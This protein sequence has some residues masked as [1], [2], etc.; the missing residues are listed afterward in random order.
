MEILIAEDD[1]ISRNLLKRMLT[2]MGHQVVEVENGRQAWDLLRKRL[3][4]F[5]VSDW[6]MPEMDG[7]ELCRNIRAAAFD[8]YIYMIV[9]TAKDRKKDL[10]EVFQAGADDYIP[11]P[12]DPEE[13]RARIMTGLRVIDLEERHKRMQSS[14]ID[15]HN[16]LLSIIDALQEQILVINSERR[17]VTAN[18]AFCRALGVSPIELVGEHLAAP[19]EDNQKQSLQSKILQMAQEAFETGRSGEHRH[20]HQGQQGAPVY[21]QF[22][23]LPMVDETAQVAQVILVGKEIH[24]DHDPEEEHGVRGDQISTK[25]NNQEDKNREIEVLR[26][27][28]AL[29]RNQM[30]QSEKMAAIGQLSAGVAHEINNPTGFVSNNLNTLKEYQQGIATLIGLYRQLG[31]LLQAESNPSTFSSGLME[32]LNAVAKLE[33]ELKIDFLLGDITDLIS[34]CLEGTRRIK[35]IVADLKHF[36]HPGEDAWQLVDINEGLTTTLNVVNHEIKYRAVVETELSE[37]PMVNGYPQEL[38]Q[39]FMNL[40]VNA[41]QAMDKNGRIRIKSRLC[42]RWAEVIVQ[43]TGCGI[44][45]ENLS[46]IFE[47]FFTTK[48]AGKG[49]GLGLYIVRN[50]VEKHKGSIDVESKIG[51]GTTFTI[52][53][54]VPSQ[55]A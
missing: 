33:Q 46:K 52:H 15:S 21:Y 29:T 14:L 40:L 34:D 41:A 7:L 10:V 24:Q 27:Q 44:P 5:V 36:V 55:A 32:K 22:T 45:A 11:K 49:T 54:P 53:L 43:D 1:F 2:D 8:G 16:D 12:F 19:S 51:E 6:M 35:K 42:D 50:I 31:D 26:Q 18:Q 30:L 23:S 17:V 4:R 25:D 20:L 38:N 37:L 47:P 9:L 28:L 13:L 3:I 39:V 48:E